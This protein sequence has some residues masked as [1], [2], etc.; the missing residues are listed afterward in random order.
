MA[1]F[2]LKAPNEAIALSGDTIKSL[3]CIMREWACDE[4]QARYGYMLGTCS[5][6]VAEAEHGLSRFQKAVYAPEA[7]AA[8]A[9]TP[10]AEETRTKE[11]DAQADANASWIAGVA[12]EW[13][14][15]VC[16]RF[17]HLK[18]TGTCVDDAAFALAN[19]SVLCRGS[20]PVDP[21]RAYV[22]G[23]ALLLDAHVIDF[24]REATYADDSRVLQFP[25]FTT[26]HPLIARWLAPDADLRVVLFLSAIPPALISPNTHVR[27]VADVL[28]CDGAQF[29]A[30]VRALLKD[31][32]TDQDTDSG[33]AILSLAPR[34]LELHVTPQSIVLKSTPR[35]RARYADAARSLQISSL[36]KDIF[37]SSSVAS[38]D[39]IGA[40]LDHDND[41]DDDDDADN[42]DEHEHENENENEDTSSVNFLRDGDMN[43]FDNKRVNALLDQ[44]LAQLARIS[45][46]RPPI[47]RF[48]ESESDDLAR[49]DAAIPGQKQQFNHLF[50]RAC[51][52]S[53][54]ADAEDAE[55]KDADAKDA[56]AKD[57]DAKDVNAEDAG[58]AN[59]AE[60]ADANRGTMTPLDDEQRRLAYY[61]ASLATSSSFGTKF[62]SLS[63][64]PEPESPDPIAQ[65][66]SESL[67]APVAQAQITR[68]E[69]AAHFEPTPLSLVHAH[70]QRQRERKTKTQTQARA[71]GDRDSDS[72][73]DAEAEAEAYARERVANARCLDALSSF[74]LEGYAQLV[75]ARDA[76]IALMLDHARD[77][78]SEALDLRARAKALAPPLAPPPS[79]PP[80]EHQ[81]ESARVLPVIS[82]P[83]VS[84]VCSLAHGEQRPVCHAGVSDVAL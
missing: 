73:S 59:H 10:I 22:C 15:A 65:S 21:L 6:V 78:R 64:P 20:E 67:S 44:E 5:A 14:F 24:A 41:D 23:A 80:P 54:D 51:I 82:P 52:A 71:H 83:S 11:A 3:S 38:R 74:S 17:A 66:Q 39:A 18:Q 56:D 7:E 70:T 9:S 76:A 45:R 27:I 47:V 26:R 29:E 12:A 77:C 68:D 53:A 25:R 32:G 42:V 40:H 36:S 58:D 19:I 1:D 16:P 33:P 28:F 60:D 50:H 63:P 57:V 48:E 37:D 8:N 79:L 69:W 61:F 30:R 13:H 4:A 35:L 81:F 2:N 46:P 31:P 62:L 55:A 75:R 34:A 43:E 72:E 84:P 49:F